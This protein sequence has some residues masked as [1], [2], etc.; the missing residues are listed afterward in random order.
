[1]LL[2]LSKM[3]LSRVAVTTTTSATAMGANTLASPAAI[4]AVV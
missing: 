3:L 1:L 2:P 4:H